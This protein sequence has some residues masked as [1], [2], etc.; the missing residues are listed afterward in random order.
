M[1][2]DQEPAPD[3]DDG[4]GSLVLLVLLACV[5]GAG[6]GAIGT[7]FRIFLEHADAWRDALIG[8][9]HAAPVMGF[10]LVT[11]G[12]AAAVALA[13]CLVRR[14]S[15]E[16]SGSG[17]PHVEAVLRKD[18]PP[19]PIMVL[20]VKFVGGLLAIGSGL[21]LGRE[22]PSVQMGAIVAHMAGKLTGLKWP[23]ARALIAAGAGAGLA[24]AFN[25]PTAGAVF[26]LEELVRRVGPRLAVAAPPPFT[27]AVFVA[28]LVYGHRPGLH[29]RP[30]AF[31]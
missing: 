4:H 9:A 11:A 28:R 18:V 31:A 27:R 25:A 21:A 30:L 15:P 7:L 24:A 8:W 29:L 22:G 20:P 1:N 2:P 26:V 14:Y 17:I 3:A 13:A 16:A 12:C 5:V 10:L 6:A 23:D 19:A